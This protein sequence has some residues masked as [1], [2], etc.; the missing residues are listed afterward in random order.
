MKRPKRPVVA[1]SIRGSIARLAVVDNGSAYTTTD[2]VEIARATGAHPRLVV[3]AVLVP[4]RSLPDVEALARVR[5]VVVQR[6]K[7][8]TTTEAMTF[9]PAARSGVDDQAEP[10]HACAGAVCRTA[11]CHRTRRSA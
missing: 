2:L 3:G 11:G 5:G 8:S 1:V 4:A 9:R 6:R 10:T 7:G